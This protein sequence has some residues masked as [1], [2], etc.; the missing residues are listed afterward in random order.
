MGVGVG[1]WS[2]NVGNGLELRYRVGARRAGGA[3]HAYQLVGDDTASNHHFPVEKGFATNLGGILPG[4]VRAAQDYFCN[5]RRKSADVLIDLTSSHTDAR[6]VQLATIEALQPLAATVPVNENEQLFGVEFVPHKTYHGA[7]AKLNDVVVDLGKTA[8]GAMLWGTA[9]GLS[10]AV[11][12]ALVAYGHPRV[13]APLAGI[14]GLVGLACMVYGFVNGRRAERTRAST[15]RAL[16]NATDMNAHTPLDLADLPRVRVRFA[17]NDRPLLDIDT[18][19]GLVD[20]PPFVAMSREVY[21]N[22]R[23]FAWSESLAA[24]FSATI[25]GTT[26]DHFA[27]DGVV[28]NSIFSAVWKS[29]MQ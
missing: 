4:A 2:R 29:L 21:L 17:L 1:S 6:D 24:L 8:R 3:R 27:D 28:T 20:E 25:R 22:H 7:I 5:Q 23:H 19:F 12:G 14:G 16:Y 10:G 15:L 26:D 18:T 11:G 13:G 9:S